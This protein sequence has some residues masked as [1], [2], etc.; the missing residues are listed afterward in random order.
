MRIEIRF[1]EPRAATAVDLGA[2]LI[3]E[4]Y[5][6]TPIRRAAPFG[7]LLEGTREVGSC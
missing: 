6:V 7:P 3:A 4:G 2:A 5:S 1:R